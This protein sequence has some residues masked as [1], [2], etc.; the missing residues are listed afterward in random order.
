MHDNLLLDYL[1]HFDFSALLNEHK[2]QY[3]FIIIDNFFVR[4]C[5]DS[6]VTIS[7]GSSCISSSEGYHKATGPYT[8]T[9]GKEAG[10]CY[11]PL[12]ACNC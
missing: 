8:W 9:L 3:G 4:Y 11:F 10:S 6:T 2:K 7:T 12:H 5:F 1:V